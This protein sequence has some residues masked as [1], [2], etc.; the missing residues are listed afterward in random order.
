MRI[1]KYASI[2]CAAVV[3][4]LVCGGNWIAAKGPPVANFPSFI[5]FVITK[6]GDVAID[7]V[8]NVY[9]NVT[10][11]NG[12]VQV[13]MFSPSGGGPE[14]VADIGTGIAYGLAVKP[15]GD[16]YAAMRTGPNENSM[17]FK[18]GRDGIPV[19]VPGTENIV[20]ANALAFDQRGNLY[21]TETYSGSPPLYDGQGGIW[22]VPP[23]GEAELW[24]RDDLLTGIGAPPPIGANGIA[25][26]HGDLYV[27]NSLR[28]PKS[29]V[30][31]VP[32]RP[33]GSPGTPDVWAELQEVPGTPGWLQSMYPPMGDGLALDVHGNVYVTMVTRAAIV[34]INAEDFSQETVASYFADPTGPPFA[35]LDAPNTIGFGTGKGGRQTLFVTNTGA[36]GRGLVK[37]EA[38]EPGLPLP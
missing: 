27:V 14:V 4:V 2:L 29:L 7:K 19:P 30:V 20:W 32:V 35:P 1:A 22:R 15:N 18:V 9:V 31:R 10:A 21:I 36:T 38:E 16:I 17:V 6:T 8:G 28:Y 23:G 33:D 26:Y 34:K 3:L 24:L 25:F 12:R 37:I 5:P 11:T 13:W